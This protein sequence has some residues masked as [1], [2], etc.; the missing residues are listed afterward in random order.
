MSGSGSS[1]LWIDGAATVDEL[2]RNV[3]VS[4]GEADLPALAFPPLEET[5][6]RL[7]EWADP[8]L[9]EADRLRSREAVADFLSSRGG[10]RDLRAEL[11]RLY[12]EG[13]QVLEWMPYW[14]K[15][16]LAHRAALPVNSNPFYLLSP[17][18]KSLGLEQAE[19]AARS[20]IAV[21]DFYQQVRKGT[22]ERDF[23]KGL[24][25][26][27]TQ[28]AGI[29]GVTRIP[30]EKQDENVRC[31][32]HH[33]TVIC[34]G[35]LFR[36]R[37]LDA[38]GRLL[39]G[40]GLARSFRSILRSCAEAQ[41]EP[42]PLAALTCLPRPRW[43]K[44]RE[45]FLGQG[46][47]VARA[48]RDVEQ[49]LFVL[50]LD[51]PENLDAER[52]SRGL[53]HGRPGDRWFDKSLQVVLLGE[54]RVGINF[55]HSARDGTPMGRFVR[56]LCEKIPAAPLE[57]GDVPKAQEVTPKADG[58]LRSAVQEA[59]RFASDLFGSVHLNLVRFEDFGRERIKELG[60]SP[61]AFLQNALFLAQD[62]AWGRCRS[63]FESVMLRS[64]R[65]GRTE[66][67]R[68]FSDGTRRFL[69]AMKDPR[70]GPAE[71]EGYLREAL[72]HHVR[73]IHLC[74]EGRGVD[75]QLGLLEAIARGGMGA[76]KLGQ[77]PGIFTCPAWKVIQDIGITTSTTSGEGIESAGYGPAQSDGLALRYLQ[78]SDHLLLSVTALSDGEAARQAFL[79][80]LPGSLRDMENL[81]TRHAAQSEKSTRSL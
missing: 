70:D 36:Q 20:V 81:M 5:C 22:L 48:I 28:Y 13:P 52:L 4:S 31:D 51:I 30:G 68:P 77:V 59:E 14:E 9:P 18:G 53:M 32:S 56:T 47:E 33:I 80:E 34:R 38:S 37:V 78:R 66:G 73:R 76:L 19:L 10:S 16:Y 1:K 72:D 27:M 24:P 26:S 21:L 40:E 65:Y 64:F 39:P 57:S 55:E 41:A 71:R 74:M 7:L 3:A 12:A 58:V 54:G 42:F 60:A 6:L 69:G 8:L 61:D 45:G 62:R 23:H 79:E 35:R 46:A 49:S 2:S 11:D 50:C 15:W 17:E 43:A 44:L 25:L 75:G 67:M 29:V 63:V